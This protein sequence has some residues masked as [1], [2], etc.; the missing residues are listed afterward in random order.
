LT[1]ALLGL[2]RGRRWRRLITAM[3][4]CSCS[5]VAA[6]RQRASDAWLPLFVEGIFPREPVKG[7]WD[8][9]SPL[10]PEFS[11]ERLDVCS[12]GSS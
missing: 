9:P 12:R 5:T 7:S 10:D 3:N 1:T 4:L 11:L 8:L 2:R 6:E